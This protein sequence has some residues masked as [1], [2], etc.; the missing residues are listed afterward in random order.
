MITMT[1]VQHYANLRNI[2]SFP[3][4]SSHALLFSYFMHFS[5]PSGDVL[6]HFTCLEVWGSTRSHAVDLKEL[7]RPAATHNIETKPSGAFG[8]VR[9]NGETPELPRLVCEPCQS[10]KYTEKRQERFRQ[11]QC[12]PLQ[13][14]RGWKKRATRI[15]LEKQRQEFLSRVF[16]SERS[17]LRGFRSESESWEQITRWLWTKNTY[18][19]AHQPKVFRAKIALKAESIT[20]Y[21]LKLRNII[22]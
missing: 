21:L 13:G 8:Q 18:R 9:V 14:S 1:N 22:L 7:S 5:E 6:D 10:Q 11:W 20:G 19:G 2:V 4:F 12:L 15:I 16:M 3:L 17:E